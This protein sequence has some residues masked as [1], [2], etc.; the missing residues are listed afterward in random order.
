MAP[1]GKVCSRCAPRLRSV[2]PRSTPVPHVA[3]THATRRCGMYHG[4]TKRT[5]RP[6]PAPTSIVYGGEPHQDHT[7]GTPPAHI[8][9]VRA[10]VFHWRPRATPSTH[11]RP[12]GTSRVCPLVRCGIYPNHLIWTCTPTGAPPRGPAYRPVSEG[13]AMCIMCK[14]FPQASNG[15]L[16]CKLCRFI[17]KVLR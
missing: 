10:C 8:G 14:R 11:V 2:C 13:N 6:H 7:G 15:T 3:P 12:K 16:L 9:V 1:S 4:H 5:R 17:G